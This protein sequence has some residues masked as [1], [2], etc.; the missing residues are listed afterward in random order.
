MFWDQ[1]VN[2]AVK[3]LAL[4]VANPGLTPSSKMMFCKIFWERKRERPSL[5]WKVFGKVSIVTVTRIPGYA[6]HYMHCQVSPK[7]QKKKGIVVICLVEFLI[8]LLFLSSTNWIGVGGLGS[9]LG[10]AQGLLSALCAVVTSCSARAPCFVP[11]TEPGMFA[12]EARAL[13]TVLS[14]QHLKDEN[15][16]QKV[17]YFPAFWNC[18]LRL[19]FRLPY[20]SVVVAQNLSTVGDSPLLFTL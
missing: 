4:H 8:T 11:G 10:G 12:W 2:T 17:L 9:H 13:T 16:T 14:L 1:R 3:S 5:T 15:I 7:K 19:A 6:G 18:H 20:R